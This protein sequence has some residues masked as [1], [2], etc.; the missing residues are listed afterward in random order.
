VLGYYCSVGNLPKIVAPLALKP[1]ETPLK[2]PL[3]VLIGPVSCHGEGGL[4][5]RA[6][7]SPHTHTPSPATPRVWTD[8]P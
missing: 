6:V 7:T 8:K 4:A 5:L 2:I 1:L 3:V